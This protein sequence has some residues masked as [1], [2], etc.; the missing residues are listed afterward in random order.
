MAIIS[1]SN[2]SELASAI[3]TAGA[4]DTISLAGGTYSL[5]VQGED[6][7]GATISAA[8][9]ATVTFS[10]LAL[11]NVQNLTIEDVDFSGTG[12]LF[13]LENS[14]NVTIRDNDFSGGGGTGFFA[15]GSDDIT[16]D[17]NTIAGY[18]TGALIKGTVGLSFRN[19]SIS[20]ISLDAIQMSGIQNGTIVGELDRS[21]RRPGGDQ[22]L[23]RDSVLR[24]QD[25]ERHDSEQPDRDRKH[26]K[27]RHLR[28]QRLL[29]LSMKISRSTIT[30]SS[31]RR[32]S[33]LPSERPT[34]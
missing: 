10:H 11:T 22:A 15:Q 20:G 21:G 18:V 29:K 4:G 16:F 8:S 19:N 14:S 5:S 25:D 1:V 30:R 3:R 9:G 13:D 7:S 2:N 12:R 32:R 34:G 17:N 24:R 26:R 23:R 31:A 6:L 27:P 33:A 28:G